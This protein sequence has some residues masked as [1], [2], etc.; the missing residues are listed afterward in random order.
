[1]SGPLADAFVKHGYR[2]ALRQGEG[3]HLLCGPTACIG[4]EQG[5]SEER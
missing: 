2:K 1:M 5:D 4:E 3:V